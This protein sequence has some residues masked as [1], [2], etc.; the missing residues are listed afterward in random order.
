MVRAALKCVG[1]AKAKR[2]PIINSTHFFYF[3]LADNPKLNFIFSR[4]ILDLS[5]IKDTL[6]KKIKA[7][8]SSGEKKSPEYSADLQEIII[9]SF[10]IAAKKE[11]SRV[12]LGDAIIALAEA[13]PY[14]K[15]I[16]IA[17]KLKPKDIENLTWWIESSEKKVSRDR[18]F[19]D[20]ENLMRHGSL[21]K[22]WAAGYTIT[23]DQ[24]AID[25][26]EI[27]KE[28]GFEEIVGH[29]QELESVERVLSG[30]GI[31]NCLMVG[32]PGVGKKSIV[33]ALSM[34]VFYGQSLPELNY[35][36]VVELDLTSLL[37]R[38]VSP[39]EV[40]AI[41]DRIFK[42]I[43]EA[44]NIILVIDEFHN[45]VSQVPRPGVVDISGVIASYLNISSF[46]TLAITSFAG[47]H[48]YIEQNPSLLS[49]FEKVEIP[50]LS[51]AETILILENLIP[52]QERKYKKF[53]T[54]PALRDIISHCGRYIQAVPFPKK[55]IDLLDEVLV[56]ATRYIKGKLILPEHVAK[57]VSEKTQI[58]VGEVE[59]KEKVVLL[60]LEKLLHEKI[61]NQEE[62]VDE[63]SESLRRARTDISV[64]K[65]PMGCFLFLGPTGVGKTETSKALAE[66]YFGSESRMI[67]LDMSEFQHVEDIPRLLGSAGQEGLL[68]TPVMENPFALLLLDELEK[69]HPNILNLFLQVLDEGYVT[70]GLG[71]KISF[72]NTI[73]IATSNAGYELILESIKDTRDWQGVKKSLLD[74][75]FAKAIF[76]PE[77][78]NRFDAV[79][80][81]KPLTPENLICIAELLLSTLK[82]NLAKKEIELIITK[83]LKEKIVKLSYNPIFGA[84]EMRRVIQDKVEDVL[85]QAILRDEIKAG[86]K[87][88][89]DPG[90]F[91]LVVKN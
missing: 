65:G 91:K 56:Y 6:K 2:I 62:A 55:A 74:Y 23:L 3:L 25:W 29:K 46:R 50:P 79:V 86:S 13:H 77:F 73:I 72:A 85:A 61:I 84:R 31:N 70:D 81:F 41:L 64:R 11:H 32:E 82:Q 71:R 8:P 40:E 1:F 47:L 67:R 59:A 68:T 33:H 7:E 80:V 28:R 75:L 88:E 63:V 49:L 54:Y 22:D 30:T 52:G 39:E 24:Y 4:A 35:K 83:P 45:Y 38:I 87:I 21:A 34:K 69:A 27:V 19:W 78:I 16:L 15:K 90:S 48:K 9:S 26:T 18:R 57:I 44:G 60:S 12:E 42:E 37:S 66:V 20:Y 17:S 58:P 53:V 14:F 43:L 89:I 51:E 36:R 76:R 10:K 5:E